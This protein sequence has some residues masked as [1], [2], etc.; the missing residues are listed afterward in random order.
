MPVRELS[1]SRV[2]TTTFV[3]GKKLTDLAGLEAFHQD[4]I[5]GH[6]ERNLRSLRRQAL[7]RQAPAYL[8]WGRKGS[9]NQGPSSRLMPR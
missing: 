4:L 2:L 7:S 6:L 8:G 3:E 9:A 1:T 5:A